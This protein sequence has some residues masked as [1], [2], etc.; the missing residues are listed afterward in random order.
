MLQKKIEFR[1]QLGVGDIVTFYFDF[2]KQNFKSYLNIFISYNGIFILA[3][4]G[5]SYLLITGFIGMANEDTMSEME[6]GLYV[7]FGS[8]AFIIVF[9]IVAAL[10]YSLSAAYVSNYVTNDTIEVDKTKVWK[11][12]K[13]N[14]SNIVLFVLLLVVIY[15]GFLI[16]SVILAII[17]IIGSIAQSILNF[18]VSG[19]F[20]VSFM[21]MI[22][23]KQNITNSFSEG[24]NLIFKNFWKTVGV[25]FILSLLN[26][27]LLF[28]I[29]SIPGILIGFYSFH[30]IDSG[31]DMSNSIVAKIIWIIALWLVLI[32]FTLF[33]SL[34][35][36]VNSI[37]YFSLHEQTYNDF[38]RAKIEQIGE[39]IE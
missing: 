28:L 10:N 38:T 4:L 18:A 1:Q 12:V 16:V 39:D 26:Y 25:N 8:L 35:Q 33:N 14:F 11:Q 30:A 7:G 29:L 27:L 19:W 15:V 6:S 9:V 36:F 23:Q 24:W 17:P 20:G 3:F 5:I 2:L 13:D 32:V 22:H 21:V 34:M 31:L 37:L